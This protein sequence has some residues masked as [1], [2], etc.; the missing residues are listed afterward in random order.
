M[1]KM[2]DLII[3]I[4]YA[5]GITVH[6]LLGAYENLVHNK[7]HDRLKHPEDLRYYDEI[8][9]ALDKVICFYRNDGDILIKE[10]IRNYRDEEASKKAKFLLGNMRRV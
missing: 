2:K 7:E 9:N 6:N 4:E 5:D 8:L 3:D 10:T 1:G